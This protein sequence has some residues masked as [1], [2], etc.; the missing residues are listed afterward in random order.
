MTDAIAGGAPAP[1]GQA[2]VT[3]LRASPFQAASLCRGRRIDTVRP[4]A[5]Q[6]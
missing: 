6:S 2:N 1:S 3:V 4:D 5:F